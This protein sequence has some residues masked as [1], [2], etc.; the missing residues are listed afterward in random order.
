MAAQGR[1]RIFMKYQLQQQNVA[2]TSQE[3]D[4]GQQRLKTPEQR[5]QKNTA[6]DQSRFMKRSSSVYENLY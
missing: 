3:F 4:S 6:Q 5:S 2:Q 1:E